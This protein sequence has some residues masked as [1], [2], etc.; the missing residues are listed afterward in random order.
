VSSLIAAR[1]LSR[2]KHPTDLP[3][4]METLVDNS[5]VMPDDF[6]YN[7][8]LVFW[9]SKNKVQVELN[10]DSKFDPDH[11]LMIL[12]NFRILGLSSNK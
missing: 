4:A 5:T 11:T 9:C 2:T 6:E 3:T 8:S 10:K 1:S 12:P 7:G